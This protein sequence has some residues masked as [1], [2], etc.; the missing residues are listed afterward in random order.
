M[1]QEPRKAALFFFFGSTT[2]AVDVIYII[3]KGTVSGNLYDVDNQVTPLF[4]SKVT[5]NY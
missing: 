1:F 4:K 2:F 3:A 5:K